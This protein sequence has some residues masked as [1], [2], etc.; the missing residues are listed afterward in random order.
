[1]SNPMYLTRRRALGLS[2]LVLL[3]A[4][5]CSSSGGAGGAP[6]GGELTVSLWG[7]AK[8]AQ[9]YEKAL[10]LYTGA[11]TDVTAKLT[12][13]DLDPYLERLTTLAA[14]K[15]LPDLMWMRDTHVGRYGGAGALLDLAPYLDKT[16]K[17]ETIGAAGVSTGKIGDGVFALPTHY[18]G[19]ALI[20]DVE[21]FEKKNISADS[22]ATWDD[23][24]GA[25]TE[26]ADPS[27]KFYGI[28][29]PTLGSTHRH[30]E[31]W[32]R[33]A[34]QEVF[35]PDGGVG[36]TS[37]VVEQWFEYWSRLRAASVIPKPDIQIESDSAG[38]TNNLLVKEQSALIAASTNHLTAVQPLSKRPFALSSIPALANSTPDWWF[39]PP[40][41]ISG[42]AN[43]ENA[44][45]VAAL[46]NFF[47]NDVNAGKITG[48]NQGAPS[49]APVRDALLPSLNSQEKSFIEQISREQ[50]NPSRPFP[51][52]PEGSEQLNAAI[53]RTG[54]E[55]AYGRE[56]VV[57]AVTKL[58]SDA[59]RALKK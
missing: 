53:S 5:G 46:I 57:D 15:E 31:A 30:L 17:T 1:M 37:D 29:D 33:Q 8:R 50:K 48:L 11:H 4:A 6:A 12:F 38:W 39:F 28:G 3:G 9:L 13:A 7:D 56:S 44:D 20:H 34:G 21:T 59:D 16:I 55:I 35:T 32:I 18:V 23:L 41:L 40:I 42:A 14:A 2:S 26:L 36:F 10:A 47:V 27:S 58:M 52:R 43:T 22:I 25:A 45:I 51:I 24:A 54:Q 19:Q 49:S